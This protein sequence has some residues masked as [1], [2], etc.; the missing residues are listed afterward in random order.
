[1]TVNLFVRQHQQIDSYL[2]AH[3]ELGNR[4]GVMRVAV[5]HL[6]PPVQGGTTEEKE[7]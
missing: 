6:C 3:P 7:G 1:M 4:S 2:Q 5:D